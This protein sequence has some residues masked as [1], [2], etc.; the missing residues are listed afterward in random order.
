MFEN[1]GSRGI[2][3]SND[4]PKRLDVHRRR[5]PFHHLVQGFDLRVGHRFVE[6]CA[7][8]VSI[9]EQ[10]SHGVIG[11]GWCHVRHCCRA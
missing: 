2:T 7:C 1:F 11:K 3:A 10:L 9:D 5:G 4:E 6:K 8:G